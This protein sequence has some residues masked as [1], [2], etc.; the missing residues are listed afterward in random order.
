[1][2]RRLKPNFPI[3]TYTKNPKYVFKNLNFPRDY[4]HSPRRQ[5][6]FFLGEGRGKQKFARIFFTSYITK[7]LIKNLVTLF[8]IL[9][10]F[11]FFPEGRSVSLKS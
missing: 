3:L 7:L 5:K 10:N 6:T 2:E 9:A 4:Q 1:M 8:Q 11:K